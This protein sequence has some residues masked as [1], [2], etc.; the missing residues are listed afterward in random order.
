MIGSELKTFVEEGLEAGSI[1]D[2]IFYQMLNSAKTMLEEERN[3]KILEKENTSQSASVGDTFL[4][5]K[6][7]PSDFANAIELFTADGNNNPIWYSPIPFR[8]RYKYKDASRRYW[9][10]L[11]NSTFGLTGKIASSQ[12][13]HLVY[14]H[15]SSEITST[16][17]WIFPS[18]FH[19]LLG[20]MVAQIQKGGA[21]YD[22]T[23][24]RQI[25]QNRADAMVLYSALLLWNEN[26]IHSEMAGKYEQSG[27]Y[28]SDGLPSGESDYSFD[29]GT[30]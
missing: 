17:S 15:T 21:D 6:T 1:N 5:T 26:L 3:W 13:I 7:L 24:A 22:A 18:R 28:D 30:L 16:G 25:I 9:I 27:N 10:D 19:A 23:T 11:V 20:F 4:T 2:T 8:L 14:R 29:L 12:T